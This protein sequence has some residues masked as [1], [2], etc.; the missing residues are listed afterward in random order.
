MKAVNISVTSKH[1]K[2]MEHDRLIKLGSG[3]LPKDFWRMPRPKDPKGLILRALLEE[4][5]TGR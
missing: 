1:M 2:K 3:R 4:R 5:K